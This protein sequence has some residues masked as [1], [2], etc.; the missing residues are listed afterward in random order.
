MTNLSSAMADALGEISSFD[1]ITLGYRTSSSGSYTT[2]TAGS[3]VFHKDR[4]PQAQYDER[5]QLAET[6]H[7]ATLKGPLSPALV[8]GYYIQV[9]GSASDEWIVENVMTKG[10]QIALCRRISV[11]DLGPDRGKTR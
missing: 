10:Q 8:K 9:G 3:W 11:G 6:I 4:V 1:G 7:T 5:G 2:L